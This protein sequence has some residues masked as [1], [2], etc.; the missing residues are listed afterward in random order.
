MNSSRW[1]DGQTITEYLLI[2]AVVAAAILGMQVYARR[3]IQAAV[4][5]AADRMSPVA[6]DTSGQAAQLLGIRQES[7]D[8]RDA[9]GRPII[10][11]TVASDSSMTTKQQSNTDLGA[12]AGGGYVTTYNADGS[13][14]QGSSTSKA[15]VEIK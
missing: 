5:T 7:G 14:T 9:L 2:F 15:V 10:G 6:G 4:K 11:A 13:T 12:T 3:G 8:S 1:R